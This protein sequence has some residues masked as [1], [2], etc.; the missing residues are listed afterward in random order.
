ML[1]HVILFLFFSL[2]LSRFDEHLEYHPEAK[3]YLDDCPCCFQCERLFFDAEHQREHNRRR[4]IGHTYAT[5]REEEDLLD[6][7]LKLSTLG[8]RIS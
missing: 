2:V 7:F 8:V 5:A 4:G 3:K 1:A 6:N